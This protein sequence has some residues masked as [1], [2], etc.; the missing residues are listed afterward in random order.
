MPV[1]RKALQN[2]AWLMD[3]AVP[4]PGGARIGLDGILGLIPGVGDTLSSVVSVWI[5]LQARQAGV[6]TTTLLK[7]VA[8]TLLDVTIGTIP[9]IGDLF[10]FYF[11]SNMRN[12]ALLEAHLNAETGASEE[13]SRLPPSR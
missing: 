10:D 8:N 2:L 7:M 11:K 6:S 13:T 4:L 5:I 3:R 9:L 1:S 12:L